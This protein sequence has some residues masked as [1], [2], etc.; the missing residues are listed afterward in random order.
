MLLGSGD[1]EGVQCSSPVRPG[2]CVQPGQLST[3]EEKQ[4]GCTWRL[5]LGPAECA[6]CLG[7]PG[8]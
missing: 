5:S 1:R 3:V 8:L 2:S 4:A 7:W 6:A